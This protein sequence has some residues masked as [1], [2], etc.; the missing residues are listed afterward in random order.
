MILY[1]PS[2]STPPLRRRVTLPYEGRD[3][4]VPEETPEE[5]GEKAAVKFG[6]ALNRIFGIQ[7]TSKKILKTD[8]HL[9]DRR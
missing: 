6:E 2:P 8:R 3:L 5:Q 4:D 7:G 9:A 1:E